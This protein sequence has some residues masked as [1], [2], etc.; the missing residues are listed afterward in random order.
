MKVTSE[1]EINDVLAIDEER[2]I[3]TLA[4]LAPEL[5]R[6]QYPNPLR[7]VIGRVTVR[8]AAQIARIPISEMLY[9]LNLAAGEKDDELAKELGSRMIS[10]DPRPDMRSARSG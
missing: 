2:M 8:Q 9:V 1:M 6:L 7:S 3:G 5:A 10:Y 4:R